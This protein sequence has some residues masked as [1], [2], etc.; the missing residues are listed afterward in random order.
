MSGEQQEALAAVRAGRPVPACVD[1][2]SDIYSLGLL[3]Y[4][5]LGGPLPP[6]PGGAAGRLRQA[7]PNVSAGLADVL[8]RCLER[9]PQDRY[10]DAAALAA[11]LQR[12]LQDLPLRGVPNR[13]L[14]ERWRKWRRRRP[15][16]LRLLL[17]LAVALGVTA[18]AAVGYFRQQV[19][20]G[21]AALAEGKALL[22]EHRHA[23][24]VR[25]FQRGLE[26]LK[27][28]PFHEDLAGELRGRLGHAEQ[29][30][31]AEERAR[32]A[33]ELHRLADRVRLLEGGDALPR[34]ARRGLEA[35][36]RSFW[37]RRAEI[38][39]RLSDGPGGAAAVRQDLLDLALFWT[40]LRVSLAAAREKKGARK[41]ALRVLAE[42]EEL[43]GPS[44]ALYHRRQ[45]HAAE[46]GLADVAGE[47]AR[48]RASLAP[49]TAWDHLA[50]GRSLLEAGA[51][52]QAAGHF[53][54]ALALAPENLWPNFYK[55]LCSCRLGEYPDAVTAFSVC[56][57]LAPRS[58]RLYY[59][60]GCAYAGCGQPDRAV[61]DY[62]RALELEPALGVAALNR[63]RI[64]LRQKHFDEAL[65]DLRQALEGGVDAAVV[66]YDMA[67]VKLAQGDRDGAL[68]DVRRALKHDPAHAEAQK[69]RDRLERRP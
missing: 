39:A 31:A 58:A 21:R 56:I 38:L 61:R 17:T 65:A 48:R 28:V 11:D 20:Q 33:G 30:R 10:P 52:R 18:G 4:K 69:L 3:L 14:R 43:F 15:H 5:A 45:V 32:W 50:L 12:H 44:A 22:E 63:G 53:E 25:A 40:D 34:A 64:R 9:R 55:G 27:H 67:R 49:R 46:A 13:S 26:H 29:G 66:Y 47:A 19:G 16:A 37:E 8:G 59:N 1:G 2:R 68:A 23:E 42:A 36:C 54:K 51:A 6:P 35:S 62:D 57:G 60:R 7:N 41:E 24:A